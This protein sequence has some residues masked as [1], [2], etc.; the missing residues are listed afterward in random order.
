[1]EFS[2]G[3]GALGRPKQDALCATDGSIEEGT[4][5]MKWQRCVLVLIV[6]GIVPASI[7]LTASQG[8]ADADINDE[9]LHAYMEAPGIATEI[10]NLRS[11]GYRDGGAHTMLVSGSCGVA[12]CSYEYLVVQVFSSSGTN[13]QTNSILARVHG[14]P[15]GKVGRVERVELRPKGASSHRRRSGCKSEAAGHQHRLGSEPENVGG[16]AGTESL[17]ECRLT[18]AEAAGRRRPRSQM[19]FAPACDGSRGA[20]YLCL[21]GLSISC[22]VVTELSTPESRRTS[23]GALRNM[24]G[25]TA[26]AQSTFEAK[27]RY[28]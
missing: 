1:M 8:V 14:G 16:A 10:E 24:P 25:T 23:V 11:H 27:D 15:L 5:L 26:K 4:H 13:P 2:G 6:A 22:A 17:T 3:T 7:F 20:S 9:I 19:T 28:S 12:G 21:N 18:T